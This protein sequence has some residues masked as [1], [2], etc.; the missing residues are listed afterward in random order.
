MVTTKEKYAK[1]NND[2][3]INMTILKVIYVTTSPLLIMPA[4][5]LL[6]TS[7]DN[8]YLNINNYNIPI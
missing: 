6:Q 1:E 2:N 7:H 8:I 4:I 3:D 5:D